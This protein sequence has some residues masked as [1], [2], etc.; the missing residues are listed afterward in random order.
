MSRSRTQK[1]WYARFSTFRTKAATMKKGPSFTRERSRKR[2]S[3]SLMKNFCSK[4]SKTLTC[5]LPTLRREL[6]RKNVR[7]INWV[8]SSMLMSLRRQEQTTANNRIPLLYNIQ[9]KSQLLFNVSLVNST[10]PANNA[11]LVLSSVKCEKHVRR[12]SRSQLCNLKSQIFKS[13][14]QRRST[15]TR[16]SSSTTKQLQR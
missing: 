9:R 11:T 2:K 8:A 1:N 14:R 16:S 7:F 10:R 15:S 6:L 3:K 5:F 13:C 12:R 4:A